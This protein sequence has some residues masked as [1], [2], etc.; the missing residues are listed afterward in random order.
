MNKINISE[1]SKFNMTNEEKKILK[2]LYLREAIIAKDEVEELFLEYRKEKKIKEKEKI[3]K[4]IMLAHQF[5]NLVQLSLFDFG[6][7]NSSDSASP[8]EGCN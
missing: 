7:K 5:I 4:E 6:H 2:N 8:K 3:I 1:L